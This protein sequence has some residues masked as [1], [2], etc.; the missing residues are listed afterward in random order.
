M[1]IAQINAFTGTGRQPARN[2]SRRGEATV[3][4]CGRGEVGLGRGM[5]GTM[6]KVSKKR[7]KRNAQAKPFRDELRDRVGHCEICGHDPKRV[8]FGA[9]A[10]ALHVHEI[11][12]GTANRHKAMDKAYATLVVCFPCHSGPLESRELWPEE[13]QLAAL[14]RSRPNDYSLAD[15]NTLVA[16]G[17]RRITE[18]D[19]AQWL[20][21]NQ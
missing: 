14:R 5:E 7:A 21:K 19:V 6:R 4:S 3:L 9:I 15:Y 20:Q 16:R 12:R 17:K 10:W 13:R 8:R 1:A 2:G 18:E 11:A